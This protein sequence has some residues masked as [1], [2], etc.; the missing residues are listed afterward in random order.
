MTNKEFIESIRLN[1]ENWRRV[2]GYED[3][4]AVSDFGRVVALEKYVK[5]SNHSKARKEPLLMSPYRKKNGYFVVVLSKNNERKRHSVHRLVAEAF[6]PNQDNKPEI[7]HI[8]GNGLNNHVENLRWC[9]HFEN[10]RNPITNRKM[11]E[12]FSKRIDKRSKQIVSI[13][14]GVVVKTYPN[15]FSVE[16]DGHNHPNVWLICHGV[17]KHHHGLRWMFLSDY[18]KLLSSSNVKE[19]SPMQ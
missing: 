4:Y 17:N 1:G 11:R 13:K 6:I 9:T 7:D 18:Q 10:M 5:R 8:D 19:L 16:K 14:D 3:L 12:S 15:I 2:A